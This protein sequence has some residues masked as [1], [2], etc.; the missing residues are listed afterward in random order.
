ME[1][2]LN[3]ATKIKIALERDIVR[4]V[5]KRGDRL[6]EQELAKKYDVSRTPV[7]EAI[8]MLEAIDLVKR[9][10]RRG[11]IV[12]GITLRRMI[13]TLE[14]H[15][16]LEGTAGM[17]AAQRIKEPEKQKL[18]AAFEDLKQAAQTGDPD[19]YYNCNM[20]FHRAIFAATYNDELVNA[21]SLYGER[22]E[23]FFRQQ[24]D[25]PG[26]IEKTM[27]EHEVILDA[28]LDHKPDIAEQTLRKHVYFDTAQFMNFATTLD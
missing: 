19:R 13:Q 18:L 20:V 22:I 11:A 10:P 5:I 23:P 24:H 16:F 9:K 27:K 4:G 12:V 2:K 14:V 6:D 26:W 7:R 17:L 28:I 15:S 21:L 3:Q 1:P 25:Q 8:A